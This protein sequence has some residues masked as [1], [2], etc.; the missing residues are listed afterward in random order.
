MTVRPAVED[1][2]PKRT[3]P[4][5]VAAS[6][7]AQDVGATPVQAA[8][9]RRRILHLAVD[10]PDAFDCHK[11]V[12]VRNFI[13][14]NPA[15]DHV[16]V[17]LTRTSDPRRVAL[18][19]GN[20]ADD[21]CVYSLRYFGLPF[22]ILLLPAM[23]VV[24]RRVHRLLKERHIRV[25]LVHAHKLCFE[26]ISGLL[27]SK[28]LRVP[29]VCSVRAEAE[30]KVLRF[31]PHY[32]PLIRRIIRRSSKIFYVSVW[33]RPEIER[34]FPEAAERGQPLPNFCPGTIDLQEVQPNPAHFVTILHLDIFKKKGLDRLLA[35][36]ARF[37][38]AHPEVSLDIIGRGTRPTIERIEALI[39]RC[40]LR[41]RAHLVGAIAHQDLLRRLPSYGAMCLPSHNETFGMVYVEAL[42]SGVPILYSTGTGIDG[43]LDGIEG[44]VGCEPSSIDAIEEGLELLLTDHASMRGALVKQHDAIESRFAAAPYVERYNHDLGLVP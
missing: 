43:F 41:G 10:F 26:G 21:P 44:A 1:M 30:S 24:A 25:D 9:A 35:A 34:W 31:M 3:V 7:D 4:A 17:A 27:L 39:E 12:A 19:P 22:G 2:L 33:Y 36:F 32:R 15:V 18:V 29:L 38:R 6:S 28:W 13:A 11:T 16:V 14:A 8:A 5:F 37:A 42:L 23:A 40:G 20:R